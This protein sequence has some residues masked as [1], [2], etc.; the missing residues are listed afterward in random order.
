MASLSSPL[1]TSAPH[2]PQLSPSLNSP[3]SSSPLPS[4]TPS[5][6]SPRPPPPVRR[7]STSS[8]RIPIP[9]KSILKK[10]PPPP[11]GLFSRITSG[12]SIGKLFGGTTTATVA[13]PNPDQT[14]LATMTAAES[15][16]G[17]GGLKRAHF[18]LPHMAVVYPISSNAPP[19]TPMTDV[20]KKAVEDR[21]RER[22]KRVVCGEPESGSGWWTMEKV[23]GFYR[24]CCKASDVK[25]EE[26]ISQALLKPSSSM[27]ML[28]TNATSTLSSVPVPAP[29]STSTSS[30]RTLDLTGISLTTT[31]AEILADVLSIEWGLRSLV[32]CESNL[33]PEVL[34]PILHALLLNNTLIYLS[35]ASNTG[36]GNKSL[37]GRAI[38]AGYGLGAGLKGA[39]VAI[40]GGGGLG[41]GGIGGGGAVTGWVV[42][43]AYL[44]N[45]RLKVLDL[46]RNVI[47]KKAME[48][49]V[50]GGLGSSSSYSTTEG[51]TSPSSELPSNSS[52]SSSLISL[53]LDSVTL[54]SGALDVLARAVRISPSLRTL[55]LRNCRIGAMGSRGGIAISLMIRDWPDTVAAPPSSSTFSSNPSNNNSSDSLSEANSTISQ[56]QTQNNTGS[57]NRL[58]RPA[59]LTNLLD[60]AVGTSS[61]LSSSALPS[62]RSSLSAITMSPLQTLV[63]VRKPLLPPPRHPQPVTVHSSSAHP[64]PP[65]NNSNL[66]PPPPLHPT[67]NVQTTYT[68]YVPRSK[69]GVA[70]GL[71]SIPPTPNTPNMPMMPGTPM[72]PVT[73]M[74]PTLATVSRGGITAFSAPFGDSLSSTSNSSDSSSNYPTSTITPRTINALTHNHAGSTLGS[75]PVPPSVAALNSASAALLSQVRALDALPRIGSLRSLDLRGNEMRVLKR[76]RTLKSLNLQDNKLDPKALAVLAEALKYNA[77][78]EELDLGRNA[79]CGAIGG[80]MS[81]TGSSSAKHASTPYPNLPNNLNAIHSRSSLHPAYPSNI[82]HNHTHPSSLSNS[83][84]SPSS[85]PPNQHIDLSLEGIH[86]LR[87]A[88]ALNATLTR[89]SL[90]DTHLGDAGAIALAEWMG[91][92]RGL[93]WLDLT[94]NSRSNPDPSSGGRETTRMGANSAGEGL[95][96]A[97]VLALAQGVKLNRTLRCLDV[98][99]PPGVEGYARLSREILNTCIRNVEASARENSG[100]GFRDT[101]D[102]RKLR[103]GEVDGDVT[104]DPVNLGRECVEELKR[105]LSSTNM[106]SANSTTM[107]LSSSTPSPEATPPSLD[108]AE[109]PVQEAN[110][111]FLLRRTRTVLEELAG[112]IGGLLEDRQIESP[113]REEKIKEVLELSDEIGILVRRVEEVEAWEGS[114]KERREQTIIDSEG[115][116]YE[117]TKAKP[118]LHVKVPSNLDSNPSVSSSSTSPPLSTAI[119]SPATVTSPP[120]T[121]TTTTH[122]IFAISDSPPSTSPRNSSS[123]GFAMQPRESSIPHSST[124]NIDTASNTSHSSDSNGNLPSSPRRKDKGKARAPPEPVRHEPVLSPTAVLLR[125]GVRG[126][127]GA[128]LLNGD[129]EAESEVESESGEEEN[130]G[131]GEVE[132][133][134]GDASSGK[135]WNGEAE[136]GVRSRSWVAEEGE[137]FRKGNVLLGPEEMEGEYDGEELR[138]E[139]LEAMVERPAPRSLHIDDP[140]EYG[141][142]STPSPLSP[143]STPISSTPLSAPLTPVIPPPASSLTPSSSL[144]A[145]PTT[146]LVSLPEHVVVTA[147]SG[148]TPTQ[149][150]SFTFRETPSLTSLSAVVELPAVRPYIPRTRSTS[151]T[152]ANAVQNT[153]E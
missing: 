141:S 112:V 143:T 77:A 97:G 144:S 132:R 128:L 6:N 28:S 125:N 115:I 63:P 106:V 78:L 39:G 43:E 81:Q 122:G 100:A 121:T 145:P 131:G 5:I 110:I 87:L 74:T 104:K 80:T 126:A 54:K 75:Q 21:E 88:L 33:D 17:S 46:S 53:T 64:P 98:E 114:H 37:A 138:R 24:E 102:E 62:A 148:T 85:Q 146:P 135:V 48:S 23:D 129:M 8:D 107:T 108:N 139:L 83:S 93:R 73:P 113:V 45:S 52:A 41:L 105:Y 92:Y 38:G 68:P 99:V 95:G 133:E 22:R 149:D 42:L 61:S 66:P 13:S 49:V 55:S 116:V 51:T 103:L 36:L 14:M 47:D 111:P 123:P 120:S 91:E 29:V 140:D 152:T 1:S 2:L 137:V 19:R 90:A 153:S 57:L 84:T 89:L 134:G 7:A 32:L 119:D 44:S 76:N 26:V 151:S 50:R 79:C 86:A 35:V 136:A 16:S 25:P 82:M 71:G 94:R 117:K 11:T 72:A 15:S 147:H 3:S 12:M 96:E 70:A 31:Q 67:K 60:E 9:G 127:S 65:V 142:I 101:P 69:R 18:I 58:R 40:T 124:F 34:K 30:P 27:T 150:Y 56:T 10:P 4:P 118:A 20:E 130:D 59:A 109:D